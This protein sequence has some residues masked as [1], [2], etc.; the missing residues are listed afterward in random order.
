MRH[1]LTREDTTRHSAANAT[2]TYE[3]NTKRHNAALAF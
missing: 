2:Q 3:H 1:N